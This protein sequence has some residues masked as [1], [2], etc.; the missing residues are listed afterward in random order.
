MFALTGAGYTDIIVQPS[1]TPF[2][3]PPGT[4][5]QLLWGMHLLIGDALAYDF[6]GVMT[7]YDTDEIVCIPLIFGSAYF[8]K[9]LGETVRKH[10]NNNRFALRFFIADYIDDNGHVIQPNLNI[11]YIVKWQLMFCQGDLYCVPVTLPTKPQYNYFDNC[12]K[13]HTERDIVIYNGDYTSGT[14]LYI[15][16]DAT[17]PWMKE[18]KK[19][20]HD[21]P[22]DYSPQMLRVWICIPEIDYDGHIYS[23][24]IKFNMVIPPSD[25]TDEHS[26]VNAVN[27]E[28]TS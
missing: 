17:T 1:V 16:P 21:V 9:A 5:P 10:N 7:S 27:E 4:I 23:G 22:K 13:F 15:V 6:E 2:W 18:A 24:E 19:I 14:W 12:Y 26:T 20:Y 25:L 8:D 11:A 28:C 3:V